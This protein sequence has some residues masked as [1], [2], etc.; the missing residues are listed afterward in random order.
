MTSSNEIRETFLRY[1]E[2]QGH[3]RVNSGSLVPKDDPTLLFTNA[4]MNQFKDVFLG[5]DK[6]GYSRATSSQ[7]CMRVSGK[8]ND[9]ETVGRTPRHHTFFEMLGNFSF[10]D[11]FKHDAIAFAW[12]L[13][14]K[15]YGIDSNR[16]IATVFEDDDEAYAIWRDEIG[17]PQDRLF[18]CD[19]K[20][21]FWAMGETGPCGPCSELHY[22]MGDRIGDTE[23]PFGVE[24]DRW[25]EIWNLVFMQYNRDSSGELTPLPS[26]SIDTGMG[27]ERI[28]SVL[29]GVS[30]NYETDLFRP[31]IEEASRL[32]NTDYG[33]TDSSD[34]SLR[35]LADHSRAAMFLIDDG[36]VPGNEGRNYVLRKILR[37]AIRHANMLGKKEPFIFTLTSLVAELMSKGY[38]ELGKSREYAAQIVRNEE[39]KFSATLSQGLTL[40][41]EV[42]SGVR[43]RGESLLPG[44][45]LFKLYDTF[46]FPFDLATE[47]SE[48]KG[49]TVD[50]EGFQRELEKQRQRARA[51]WKGGETS[52]RPIDRELGDQHYQTEFTGYTT[53]SDVEGEILAIVQDGVKVK[54]LKEGQVGE[55]VLDRTP[56]YAEAGGQIADTGIIENDRVRAEVSEVVSPVS[57]LRL[58]RVTVQHG[59]LSQGDRVT[60]AV[61]SDHR[62]PTMRNHTATHLL[63]AALRETLG[64]HVKQSGSLV[65]PDR[66]RFDFTHYQALS[67]WELRQIESR[68]N[69]KI[70]DNIKVTTEVKDLDE[71]IQAGAMALFG[72][73]YDQ[74]VRV[75]IIPGFSTELCGGTHVTR[76][77]DISLFKI[78]SEGSIS[79]GVRRIEAVTGAAAVSRFLD[80]DA[81]LQTVSHQLRVGRDQVE[82]ALTRLVTEL[83]EANRE[84]ERLQLELAR[85]E[86][87]DATDSAREICGVDVVAQKVADADRNTLRQ[88]ADQ[89]R[90]KLGSGI[91]VLGS[92]GNGRVSLV[93]MVSKDLT[94]RLRAD[95]L[96]GPIAQVVEGGGGGKADMAE[97]GGKKPELLDQ[98]LAKTYELV[99]EALQGKTREA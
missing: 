35:I 59:E 90:N 97:A 51:S 86:S 74:N 65:A 95:K 48:E 11:Y 83:R 89:I 91:V 78:T 63:H 73:K 5:R 31:L 38:P 71:A 49:L 33:S 94:D 27:L 1:F 47:I 80:E 67:P 43:S 61:Y 24:S 29:Q 64:E 55:V 39:E 52:V 34:V 13:C 16:L 18:R 62:H 75:V 23:T 42:I 7:K 2:E 57:G 77:G 70:R 81:L 3:Q 28:T 36:V 98:A 93:V 19:A 25:V 79:S 4:G 8:H 87:A 68:V 53:I 58:H 40:L 82:P 92:H 99:E 41:E 54:S 50:E 15:V 60:S 66:L 76:T 26:P 10:G 12:E 21:N 56:F 96:V 46:G 69:E 85:K 72:E 45:E 9:L 44:E 22:D 32:T 30:S 88:L 20:E 84:I 37:R 14:T 17:I 6:R